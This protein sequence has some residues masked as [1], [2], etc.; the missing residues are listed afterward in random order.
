VTPYRVD[1]PA[2]WWLRD[3][4]NL[5]ARLYP[6]VA[7]LDDA[8]SLLRFVAARGQA[9]VRGELAV[10]LG[11]NELALVLSLFLEHRAGVDLRARYERALETMGEH[12]PALLTSMQ[13]LPVDPAWAERLRAVELAVVDRTQA[14]GREVAGIEIV[15]S[16]F[17]DV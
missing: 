3:P 6:L 17:D 11:T 1:P 13:T 8:A 12:G 16:S 4:S 10:M 2:V 14:R 7:T 5:V 9:L 15:L